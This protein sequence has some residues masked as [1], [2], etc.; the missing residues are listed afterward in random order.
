MTVKRFVDLA[1]ALLG[2][3]VLSLV[4]VV[5]WIVVRIKHGS[6]V[7]FCQQRPGL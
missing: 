3:F 1:A 6:P 4:M 2:M 7:L 5:L